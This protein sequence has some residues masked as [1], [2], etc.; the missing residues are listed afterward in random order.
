MYDTN[1]SSLY[2]IFSDDYEQVSLAMAR[3]ISQQDGSYKLTL[4]ATYYYRPVRK[5]EDMYSIVIVLVDDDRI[6]LKAQFL[7]TNKVIFI[8]LLRPL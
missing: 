3:G 1:E 7:N 2:S 4:N 6:D 5:F 8:L